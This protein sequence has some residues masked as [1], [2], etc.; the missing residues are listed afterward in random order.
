MILAFLM[1]KNIAIPSNAKKCQSLLPS[2]EKII[3]NDDSAS[4][5]YEQTMNRLL[6]Q[7]IQGWYSVIMEIFFDH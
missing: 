4:S 1:L 2:G 3:K 6:T 5:Y 7:N